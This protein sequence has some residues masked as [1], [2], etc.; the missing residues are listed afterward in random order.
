MAVSL[1]AGR[2]TFPVPVNGRRPPVVQTDRANFEVLPGFSCCLR[3]AALHE[4][5]VMLIPRTPVNIR[6]LTPMITSS[7]AIRVNDDGVRGHVWQ[8]SV[9]PARLLGRLRR[10]INLAV[11]QH[12]AGMCPT[13]TRERP[14]NLVT[15]ARELRRFRRLGRVLLKPEIPV[16]IGERP[17]LRMP[18]S[19]RPRLHV[20]QLGSLQFVHHL[21]CR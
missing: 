18:Q 21:L 3:A 9:S 13:R 19:L 16:L 11:D 10:R 17:Q 12:A 14:S 2:D 20:P 6:P 8:G 5:R 1:R 4:N 15:G 7:P